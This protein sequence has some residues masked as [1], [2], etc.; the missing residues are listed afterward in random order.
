MQTQNHQAAQI[1]AA[2]FFAEP[3]ITNSYELPLARLKAVGLP[4]EQ[5]QKRCEEAYTS[6]SSRRLRS[7]LN[8][9][10]DQVV[11]DHQA[12]INEKKD[13]CD[14][15]LIVFPEYSILQSQL[16]LVQEFT[17]RLR[18]SRFLDDH[19]LVVVAGSHTVKTESSDNLD[20]YRSLGASKEEIEGVSA[21]QLQTKSVSVIF[22]FDE[23]TATSQS[24]NQG[25]T[26]KLLTKRVLSPFELTNTQD[27]V[28]QKLEDRSSILQVSTH[29][30]DVRLNL[31]IC[32]EAIQMRVEVDSS[33]FNIA[34]V[35]AY[36]RK[37]P[38]ESILTQ[39]KNNRRLTIFVNDGIYGGSGVFIPQGRRGESWWFDSPHEGQ[40]PTG[41]G[42]LVAEFSLFNLAEVF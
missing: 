33:Q 34:I 31:L 28:D 6:W 41:D 25:V 11:A 38:F 13:T 39:L 22:S 14:L 7:V 32:A 21:V 20:F 2:K 17:I 29:G 5:M 42:V 30:R 23:N 12:S 19:A 16:P 3:F 40:L 4:V 8:A 27:H 35:I 37:E 9:I 15:T 36:S 26:T 18:Q 1:G 10:G 24:E